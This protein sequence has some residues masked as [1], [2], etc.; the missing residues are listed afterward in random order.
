M[1]YQGDAA[2]FQMADRMRQAERARLATEAL[3]ARNPEGGPQ[4]R[5]ISG[6]LLAVVTRPF[7]Q[8]TRLAGGHRQPARRYRGRVIGA[9]HGAWMGSG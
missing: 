3:A 5:W 9:L 6:A 8:L 7:L 1:L 2:K 4:R